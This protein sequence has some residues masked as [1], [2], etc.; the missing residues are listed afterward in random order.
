[1][2]AIKR[3]QMEMVSHRKSID[4]LKQRYRKRKINFSENSKANRY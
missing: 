2:E 4:R 1:M 3:L